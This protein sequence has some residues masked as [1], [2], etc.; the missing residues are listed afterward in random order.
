MQRVWFNK[1]FSSV[2]S[3]IRLIREADVAGDYQIV[4]SSTNP[5]ASAFLAAQE[6]AVEPESLRGEAYLAWCL[7]FCREQCIDIFLPGKE[8]SLISGARALFAAQG[9]RVMSVASQEVLN[10]LHD[11]AA[12]YHSVDLPRTP[13]ADFRVFENITQF[14]AAYRELRGTHAQLCV[15]PSVSVYGLGFS[16][17]DEARSSA[18]LLLAGVQYHI[19]H[20]DLRRG[21]EAMGDF[22]TMLLMEYLDGHEYSVDCIGDN[23]RL[24]CAIPRK[25][26]M[27]AGVGQTIDLRDDILQST[28]DLAAAYSL[29][30]VFNVQFREGRNGLGL[31]EINPRMSGGVAMACLAG[32]NLPYLALIGFDRGFQDVTV[33]P[34]RS[35]IRVGEL[36]HATEL[37]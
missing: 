30:G 16:V 34:I 14:D 21:F 15:K 19:G 12:F 5:Q 17:V 8:A 31:L 4:C 20:E 13:P 28:R 6:S 22:R 10:L 37:R 29:N 2:G 26:S 27:I 36:P 11:K 7:R 32:P 35:G 9:T 1:T 23:G 24:I 18:Q 3:A 25:K 33:P